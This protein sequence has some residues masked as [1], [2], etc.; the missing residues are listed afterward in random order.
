M[1]NG[2]QLTHDEAHAIA[3]RE[4]EHAVGWLEASESGAAMLKRAGRDA[5][6]G[7]TAHAAFN[8]LRSA[9]LLDA[10]TA[11]NSRAN[12]RLADAA[13][14]REDAFRRRERAGRG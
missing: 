14:A 6:L 12:A 11:A 10:S 2:K 7:L 13:R 8:A 9:G 4:A 3:A 1:A 5:L